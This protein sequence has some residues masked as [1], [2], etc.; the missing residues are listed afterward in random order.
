MTKVPGVEIR[1]LRK[2]YGD[3][4]ALA[5]LDL[6]AP[7]GEITGVAG[8]N[9]A[10][11]S[12]M[13]RILAGEESPDQGEILVEGERWTRTIG[14]Q[15]VA[16]VHQEPQ[17]FPNLTVA[18]NLM[19]GRERSRWIRRGLDATERELLGDLAILVYA[20]RPLGGLP[21]AV[22]QRTEIARALAQEARVFLFD[23][24]NSALTE[25]E[26]DDLFRHL[27]ALADAGRTVIFVS[28]RLT[29]LS[30]H[31]QRVSVLL[32]GRRARTLDGDKLN[33]EAIARTLV[34]GFLE[35]ERAGR[36]NPSKDAVVLS[37]RGLTDHDGAFCGIDLDVHAGSLVAFA[38][39]EGSGARDLVRAVAGFGRTRGAINVRRGPGARRDQSFVPASRGDSLFPNLTVGQNVVIRLD[40]EITGPALSLR[41]R[42]ARALAQ[43]LSE[44]F[45]V[46]AASIDAP[47]RSLSGG[48]QQKVAIAAAI[49]ARPAVLVLEEP[50]RGVD[51]G[52]KREIY[53]LLREYAREG[54][55]VIF[56]STEIPEVFE[57]A[58]TLYVVAGGRLSSP[59][60][61]AE[62]QN[63]ESLAGAASEL[64]EHARDVARAPRIREEQPT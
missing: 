57:A 63:V 12:T 61:V 55:A 49:A 28:H 50:T 1:S 21:L 9:G 41:R 26:S 36:T 23:E 25:E 62:F 37:V 20:D 3:T 64:E 45:M 13:I 19:V 11:K 48:N 44:R 40:D 14:A 22:Q 38:G 43:S 54:H 58:H 32:D 27:H 4:M 30:E 52:A 56:Y 46:K 17:L 51:I 24:P 53:G 2:T 29:E 33:P 18:E 7:A 6:V 60:D 31:S 16:V 34:A 59:L 10:G 5:G 47:I 39:V 8:P 15:R 42:R 35:S